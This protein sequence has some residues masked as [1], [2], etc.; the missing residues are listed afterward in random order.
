M[1]VLC[2][3]KG[4]DGGGGWDGG[5]WVGRGEVGGMGRGGW[6][7]PQDAVHMVAARLG[8]QKTMVDT[9]RATSR[10]DCMDWVRKHY[11]HLAEGWFLARKAGLLGL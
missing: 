1:L 8:F 5:R 6:G 3:Q 11:S 10:H 7:H 4:W 2:Q 9:R